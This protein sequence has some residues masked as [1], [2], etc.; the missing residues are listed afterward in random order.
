MNEKPK[1]QSLTIKYEHIVEKI[2]TDIGISQ[3][4]DIRN[5]PAP[6]PN[7][8]PTKALWDTGATISIITKTVVD[9][10]GLIPKGTILM[11]HGAGS[12]LTNTYQ[13]N[14]FLPNK[15]C[16]IAVLVAEYP[17]H[18]IDYKVV[19]G[20]DI[21]SKGDFSI[22]QSGGKTCMTFRMPSIATIDYVA[23]SEKLTF[24][25]AKRNE[26]CRCGKVDKNGNPV[27][28]KFCHGGKNNRS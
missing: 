18:A 4:F 23:E 15:V 8:H 3:A 10:L 19:L 20:M 24:V 21:I 5:P 16:M 2:V 11:N 17:D 13:T 1:S 12:L 14:L 26:P 28:Y 22:T 7:I 9:A 27:L 25:G 6:Q